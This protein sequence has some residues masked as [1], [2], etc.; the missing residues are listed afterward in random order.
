MQIE[1]RNGFILTLNRAVSSYVRSGFVWLIKSGKDSNEDDIGSKQFTVKSV[2]EVKAGTEYEIMALEH[3]KIKYEI[4]DGG[5]T[6][7]LDDAKYNENEVVATDTF[8]D[9]I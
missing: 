8:S 4:I 5:A 3:S 2:K 1:N 9:I 7:E 6:V